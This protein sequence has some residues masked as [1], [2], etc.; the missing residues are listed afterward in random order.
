MQQRG[1]SNFA[2]DWILVAFKYGVTVGVLSRVLTPQ[3]ITAMNFAGG[4]EPRQVYDG[5]ITKVGDYFE[6]GLCKEDKKTFW[7]AKKNAPR[8]LRKFHFGLADVCEIWYVPPILDLSSNTFL[9]I[10]GLFL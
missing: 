5:F 3:E 4:F 6:C 7:K 8:H 1:H 2:T 9:T 10:F